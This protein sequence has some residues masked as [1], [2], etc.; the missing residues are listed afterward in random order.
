MA[1][2]EGFSDFFGVRVGR[3]PTDPESLPHAKREVLRLCEGSTLRAVREDMVRSTGETGA[4]Y[5][6]RINQFATTRW[7]VTA[8]AENSNSLSRAINGIRALPVSEI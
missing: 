8:A 1:D 3:I 5:V 4:L 7:D 6:S 2:R